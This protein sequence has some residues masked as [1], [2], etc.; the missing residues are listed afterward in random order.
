MSRRGQRARRGKAK[1]EV[2]QPHDV[3]E[4]EDSEKA[5]KFNRR[6]SHIETVN[7]GLPADFEDESIDEDEAFNDEDYEKFGDLNFGQYKRKVFWMVFQCG[8]R[9]SWGRGFHRFL[10]FWLKAWKLGVFVGL[11]QFYIVVLGYS[12]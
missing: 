2:F 8:T 12:L 3:Y 7:V 9:I 6:F 10:G 1:G 11:V 4:E 5:S